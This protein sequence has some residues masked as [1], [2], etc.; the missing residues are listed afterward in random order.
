VRRPSPQRG[1]KMVACPG[2]S[3]EAAP[4]LNVHCRGR[5]G[6]PKSLG[7]TAPYPYPD[8]LAS[9]TLAPRQGYV[10]E[11]FPCDLPPRSLVSPQH[12]GISAFRLSLPSPCSHPLPGLCSRGLW[13]PEPWGFLTELGWGGGRSTKDG[14]YDGCLP[15]LAWPASPALDGGTLRGSPLPVKSCRA[16]PPVPT[17]F[18]R[19]LPTV[20]AFVPYASTPSFPRPGKEAAIFVCCIHINFVTFWILEDVCNGRE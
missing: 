14:G 2:P 15:A 18:P 13:N 5:T 16:Y 10:G 9:F 7:A 6:M 20:A 11:P 12:T 8:S 17:S 3:S 19:A 4:S 1:S